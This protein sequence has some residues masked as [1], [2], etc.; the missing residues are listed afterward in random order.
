MTAVVYHRECR[1]VH[2]SGK[3]CGRPFTT[4]FP[5]EV[6]CRRCRRR[7]PKCGNCRSVMAPQYGYRY[8]FGRKVGKYKI[9]DDCAYELN[10]KGYIRLSD[11]KILLASGSVKIIKKARV[12]TR[13]TS[14]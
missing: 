6:L 11:E 3:V 7:L 9:C 2:K 4:S 10:K 8:G 5:Q 13:I 1:Y 14:S 12:R